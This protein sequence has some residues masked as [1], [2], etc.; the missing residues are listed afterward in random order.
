MAPETNEEGEEVKDERQE[1][2]E[3]AAAAV[4]AAEAEAK[5]EAEARHK[6]RLGLRLR[7]CPPPVQRHRRLHTRRAG[8]CG[9]CRRRPWWCGWWGLSQARC[10]AMAC[11]T[12]MP[13]CAAATD[14]CCKYIQIG[15][16]RATRL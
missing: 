4:A 10:C 11:S 12:A 7:C 14:L 13:S 9:E 6:R 2:E 8:S 15:G 3:E 1:E 16:H 5:A